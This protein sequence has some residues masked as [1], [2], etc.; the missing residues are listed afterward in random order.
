MLV[1]VCGTGFSYV[2]VDSSFSIF[3]SNYKGFDLI[4]E[5]PATRV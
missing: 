5:I 3:G 1:W 4:I 2:R